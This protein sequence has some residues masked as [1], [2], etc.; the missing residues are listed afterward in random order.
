MT[1]PRGERDQAS[2]QRRLDVLKLPVVPLERHGF[3]TPSD[4]A[5]MEREPEAVGV[6]PDGTAFA[7]WSNRIDSR[8]KQVTWHVGGKGIRTVGAIDVETDLR[9]SFV[10]PLR[11]G[12]DGVRRIGGQCRLVLPDGVEAQRL[13]YTCRSGRP[14]RLHP[15]HLVPNQHGRAA[16]CCAEFNSERGERASPGTTEALAGRLS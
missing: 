12:T 3:L 11:I 7:V 8:R 9:V 5:D 10:Q 1:T 15:R 14:A 13:R 16:D 2:L 4:R 6:G